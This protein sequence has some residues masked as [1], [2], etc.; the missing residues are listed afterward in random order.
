MQANSKKS[1]EQNSFE[2]ELQNIEIRKAKNEWC[3]LN[4]VV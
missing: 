1:W 4:R 3:S 2:C